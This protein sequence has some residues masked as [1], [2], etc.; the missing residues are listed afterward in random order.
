[1]KA[2][3]ARQGLMVACMGP[4]AEFYQ[5]SALRVAEGRVYCASCY[6]TSLPAKNV[7]VP[8]VRGPKPEWRKR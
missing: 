8:H 2:W 3:D 7:K 6:P 4:C 5:R 1:M